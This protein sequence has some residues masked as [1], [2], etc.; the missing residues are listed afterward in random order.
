MR[1]LFVVSAV[2]F[3]VASLGMGT[4]ASSCCP[5]DEE[6]ETLAAMVAEQKAE[7]IE[8]GTYNCCLNNPCN[9]CL[10]DMGGCPCGENVLEGEPVCHECKGG[11]EAGDGAFED[12]DPEDVQVMP[13]GM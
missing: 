7:A 4:L 10:I 8:D 5:E 6:K 2:L 3:L 13:R 11:W 9:Q 12:I 1:F